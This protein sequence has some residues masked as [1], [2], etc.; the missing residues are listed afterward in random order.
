MSRTPHLPLSLPTGEISGCRVP[1]EP[2]SGTRATPRNVRE[3]GR[4]LRS[5]GLAAGLQALV[6]GSIDWAS[7]RTL[8]PV[9]SQVVVELAFEKPQAPPPAMP[10]PEAVAPPSALPLEAAAATQVTEVPPTPPEPLPPAMAELVATASEPPPMPV[11]IATPEPEPPPP[12]VVPPERH[13]LETALEPVLT[14]PASLAEETTSSSA[15][16]RMNTPFAKPSDPRARP[17]APLPTRRAQMEPRHIAS[18]GAAQAAPTPS[19]LPGSVLAPASTAQ[20]SNPQASDAVTRLQGRI[21]AAIQAA[22]RYPPAATAMQL[23]GRAQIELEYQSGS[24]RNV[25]L[26]RSAGSPVLDRAAISAVQSARY[27]AAPPEVGERSLLL[28]VWVE[29]KSG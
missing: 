16:P 12:N 25:Q 19:T 11:P 9:P 20:T 7:L 17:A 14:P 4:L 15:P 28:L 29:L 13:I 5:L 1:L 27:P 26:A 23:T 3:R 10:D 8:Q 22:L 2:S 21:R 18:S 24:V 6:I